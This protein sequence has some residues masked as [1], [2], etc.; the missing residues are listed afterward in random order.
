MKQFNPKILRNRYLI[1]QNKIFN[2]VIFHAI[3]M[4]ICLVVVYLSCLLN[5]YNKSYYSIVILK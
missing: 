5:K 1:T 4:E 3:L 2:Y